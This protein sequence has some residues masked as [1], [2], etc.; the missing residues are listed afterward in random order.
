MLLF[1]RIY[2][3]AWIASFALCGIAPLV[4]L[5]QNLRKAASSPFAVSPTRPQLSNEQAAQYT[6]SEVL[7]YVGLAGKEKA[8]PWDPLADPLASNA[9]LVS[10][11]TV[12]SAAQADDATV[13]NTVQAAV[14]RAVA[15]SALPGRAQRRVVVLVKAGVYRELLYVPA[16]APITLLGGD[17][18]ASRT[19]IRASLDAGMTGVDYVN[20][21]GAQ[22]AHVEPGIQAMFNELKNK[23][24]LS[25]FGSPV[26]WIR[27][28]GFQAKNITFENNYNEDR[29]HPD[30]IDPICTRFPGNNPLE[31]G[32]G[33]AVALFVDGADK[34][35]FENVRFIGNQDTL[36]LRSPVF[37]TTV[38][39]FFHKSYIEGDV[40][41]IFGD[42]TA[43]FYRS[44][45]KSLGAR[46]ASSYAMAPN[47]NIGT[48]Y[49]FV[50]NECTFTNDGSA[51]ALAGKFYLARQW[52]HRSKCTPYGTV[53]IPGYSCDLAENDIYQ[54]PHGTVSKTVLETVGKVIILHSRIGSHIDKERP[55]SDWNKNGGLSYRPVHYDL[56][57][58][59]TN[60]A[61]T[62]IDLIRDLGY[63]KKPNEPF[64]AEFNNIDEGRA[65]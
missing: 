4:G 37:L 49:G 10:D 32:R 63:E 65:P 40:D 15:D 51:N 13:F 17:T 16:A 28:Q 19:R 9:L 25:T 50:F 2:R 7:K 11:Y 27:N 8:D 39:S 53:N 26:V 33:Q 58:F 43:Y 44:E 22:F 38:R 62:H 21:F 14:N 29:R 45:I 55:W 47:T 3:I 64:L 1:Y 42:T 54:A 35:Q 41:F 5:A 18:D 46:S 36:F 6:Y 20:N 23:A 30:C 24:T 56:N 31:R 34:V 59:W 57:T 12:D 48:R 52:F 61:L 60:L